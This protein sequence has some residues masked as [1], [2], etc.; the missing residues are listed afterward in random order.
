MVSPNICPFKQ[1]QCWFL[2]HHTLFLFYLFGHF[3]PGSS[4]C[5]PLLCYLPDVAAKPGTK[6]LLLCP[7]SAP[8]FSGRSPLGLHLYV[9]TPCH[10]SPNVQS[11]SPV[12]CSEVHTCTATTLTP[13]RGC[14]KLTFSQVF[15]SSSRPS[16]GN[17]CPCTQLFL[18]QVWELILATILLPAF[19]YP[20]SH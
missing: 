2:R 17:A 18:P 13:P 9:P 3:F 4:L 7:H 19:P 20:I 12:P 8:S 15:Y 11:S 5:P 16:S 1:H 10:Q 14:L 6:L